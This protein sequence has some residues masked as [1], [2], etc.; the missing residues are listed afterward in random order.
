MHHLASE[1]I[2]ELDKFE[3]NRQFKSPVL[4]KDVFHDIIQP[5]LRNDHD[6]WDNTSDDAYYFDPVSRKFDD[7]ET[8]LRK[9]STHYNSAEKKAHLG[10]D[11]C[12]AAC[13]SL[14]D[15]MQF[16]F[17]KGICAT[18][19]A[20]RFGKPAEVSQEASDNYKSGWMVQR[21][22]DWAKKHN[23]CGTPKFPKLK[24]DKDE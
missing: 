19:T 2:D 16:R 5:K 23:D 10:F 17:G 12:R 22:N 1:E 3:L 20:V 6:D 11:E 7:T 21:I 9:Q 18:S 15:C 13:Q 8:R 24:Y 14:Q 4:I